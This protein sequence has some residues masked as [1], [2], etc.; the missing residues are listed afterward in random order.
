MN[1]F[2]LA[3]IVNPKAGLS[4]RKFG[5]RPIDSMVDF[6][7][8]ED[9]PVSIATTSTKIDAEE[10]AARFAREGYTH[11]LACGGDGTINSVVNGLVGSSTVMGAI[12]LGTENVFCKAMGVSMD[13]TEACQHF[14]DAKVKSLDV[15]IANHRHFL[16]TSGI[17]FDA[18][19]VS[20]MEEQLKGT[21]GS[22]GFIIKGALTMLFG[23]EDLV[24]KVQVKFNDGAGKDIETCAWLVMVGNIPNYSGTIQLV[25]KAEPDDGLLDLLVFP[26]SE[27]Q[28][29][30]NQ[31]LELIA[32]KSPEEAGVIYVT[33][34]DFEIT[35]D[36]PVYCQVDGEILGQTPVHYK[37]RHKALKTKI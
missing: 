17:G 28:E 37:V 13:V 34:S 5:F 16:I 18:K 25:S 3:L 27:K 32:E 30:T 15:G 35:S 23:K 11:V 10:L 19:I 14:M 6:F 33:S 12:P 9:I 2:R 31:V 29:M 20:E 24:S 21:L 4:R 8:S 36:P 7:S 22:V 26:Y 1:D